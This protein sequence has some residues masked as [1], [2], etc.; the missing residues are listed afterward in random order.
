M[1]I[2]VTWCTIVLVV[3]NGAIWQ[4]VIWQTG[5]SGQCGGSTKLANPQMAPN[6][7][8]MGPKWAPNGPQM[9]P[10]W[11]PN[12]TPMGQPAGQKIS[13]PGEISANREKAPTGPVWIN[14]ARLLTGNQ[15]FL[16]RFPTIYLFVPIWERG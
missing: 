15:F 5:E 11:A 3:A 2:K 16:Q 10:K 7:P 9:G 14:R 4:A 6:G 8:Q 13:L 12:G 1:V